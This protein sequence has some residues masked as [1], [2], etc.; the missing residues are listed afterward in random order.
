[1]DERIYVAENKRSPD[2]KLIWRSAKEKRQQTS[3]N[4]VQ[5]VSAARRSQ[6]IKKE[7]QREKENL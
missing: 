6:V 2:R 4:I 1:M 3:G 7:R 5:F